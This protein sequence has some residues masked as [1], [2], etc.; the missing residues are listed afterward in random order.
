MATSRQGDGCYIN[1]NVNN[2]FHLEHAEFVYL[3]DLLQILK[4]RRRILF[5]VK[6]IRDNTRQLLSDIV[7]FEINSKIRAPATKPYVNISNSV[8]ANLVDT[9]I[10]A[11]DYEERSQD[12][13]EQ[14]GSTTTHFSTLGDAKTVYLET[15]ARIFE[16]ISKNLS[17]ISPFGIF[18]R[19]SFEE[20]YWLS[21]IGQD[22]EPY[23]I[24]ERAR[25]AAAVSTPRKHAASSTALDK[26]P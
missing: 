1:W 4:N 21:W 25:A 7:R 17:G 10:G 18:I 6:N 13:E 3:E 14:P 15:I 22:V 5:H 9:I 12:H 16:I 19:E 8:F 20:K 11:L 23:D 2:H 26:A 24:M